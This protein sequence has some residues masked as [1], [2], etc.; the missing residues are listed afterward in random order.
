MENASY[1]TG[2][3]TEL[4][5]DAKHIAIVPSKVSGPDAFCAGAGLYHMLKEKEKRVSF[6]YPGSIPEVC[7]GLIPSEEV[8]SDVAQKRLLV[9]IDYSDTEAATA[10]YSNDEGVLR[11]VVAPVS[12]GFDI[13]KNVRT[14]IL[15]FDADLVITVGLQGMGDLGKTYADL[16]GVLEKAKV[17]NIDNTSLNTNFG[18]VNVLDTLSDSLSLLVFNL[19]PKLEL[20]SKVK[21]AT[22]LL[23]GITYRGPKA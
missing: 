9:S 21:A 17:I 19:S 8:V 3:I 14:S 7:E 6:I 10:Q 1:N 5:N 23:K 11:L 18:D 2:K 12:N 20:V 15:G 16:K 22:A 4:I 13:N